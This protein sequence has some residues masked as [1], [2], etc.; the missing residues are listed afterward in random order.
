[1][2]LKTFILLLIGIITSVLY[3]NRISAKISKSSSLVL[4]IE[5]SHPRN[6]DQTSLI[7]RDK[8]I[9]FVTNSFQI[10][11]QQKPSKFLLGH[12]RTTLN[13]DFK[14]LQKKIVSIR[15]NL[16]SKNKKKSADSK[17]KKDEPFQL[18]PHAPVIHIGGDGNSLTIREN[19]THFESLRD[20]LFKVRDQNWRCISCAKYEKKGESIVRTA[21]RENQ[22]TTSRT[23]SRKDLKCVSLNK[24][25]IEC[26]DSQFGIFEL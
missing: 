22:K 21:E 26:I 7:F 20:I 4:Q 1:M 23:F 25:R 6:T 3:L 11:S 15:N 18:V 24:K 12:F 2:N 13:N 16:I 5:I 8:T 10:S 19:D 9:D 14:I 17:T